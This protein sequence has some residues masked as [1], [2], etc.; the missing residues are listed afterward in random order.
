MSKCPECGSYSELKSSVAGCLVCPNCKAIFKDAA[1]IKKTLTNKEMMLQ[2]HYLQTSILELC[3][4]NV[5]L[6]KKIKENHKSIQ[7]LRGQV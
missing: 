5:N 6:M 2:I 1:V 3:K 4:T 7:R